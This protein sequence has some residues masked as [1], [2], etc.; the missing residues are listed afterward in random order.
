MGQGIDQGPADF[1]ESCVQPGRQVPRISEGP[2]FR[3]RFRAT[4]TVDGLAQHG[5]SA[6]APEDTH[7]LDRVSGRQ[8]RRFVAEHEQARVALLHVHEAAGYGVRH[9]PGD[10]DPKHIL[11]RAE[12]LQGFEGPKR[13][14]VDVSRGVFFDRDAVQKRHPEGQPGDVSVFIRIGIAHA[15]DVDQ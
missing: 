12:L 13:Q 2:R 4:S 11:R 6:F 10:P 3:H 7:R 1:D 15:M 5:A 9:D 14:A 8:W